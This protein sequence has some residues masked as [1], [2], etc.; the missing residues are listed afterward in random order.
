ML[1]SE[2]L[3]IERIN[4]KIKKLPSELSGLKIVQLSDLHYDGKSLSRNLLEKAIRISNNENPNLIALTGDFV[5]FNPHAIDNLTPHLK[6]LKSQQKIYAC[7]GNHDIY[8][9]KGKQIVIDSLEAIGIEVLW[10]KIDYIFNDKLAI[11]GLAD[12]WSSEFNPKPIFEQ[13]KPNI[14][15]IVLSHN[16]DT[17]AILQEFSIDLQ[18]SGH[19]HG[20]QIVIPFIGTVPSIV[21]KIKGVTP[22]FLHPFIPYLKMCSKIMKHWEWSEG[23]HKIGDNQLYVNRGL[24]SYSPG[25]LFCPPELTVI[26][27][28]PA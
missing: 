3:K 15:K 7:L 16:P 2:D 22:P 8:Y 12:I 23:Y 5:T 10:N 28:F 9:K 19:T 21:I 27:L 20:G 6:H 13:I 25:R 11:V 1:F 24:G 17:M 14:P 4:I 18:L 26:N